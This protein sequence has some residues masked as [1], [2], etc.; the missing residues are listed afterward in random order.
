[1]ATAPQA[2]DATYPGRPGVIVFNMIKFSGNGGDYTGGLYAIRP[3]RE[4]PRQLTTNAWDYDPSFAPSGKRLVFRRTNSPRSGI[5]V[6][7]LRGGATKRVTSMGSDMDPAF[8]PQGM[9]VFSRFVEE[10]GYD[11]FLRTK[12]GRLRRLTSDVGRDLE[13][14]FT[15]DGERIVFFRDYRKAVLASL[16]SK[17]ISS[18]R[19]EGLYS[20]RIDGGGLRFLGDLGQAGSNFDISPSGRFLLFS[21]LG[22][23]T[24]DSV[25]SEARTRPIDGGKSRLVSKN[26]Q[27]STYSPGGRK[28]AYSNYKGLWVRATNGGAPTRIFEAEYRPFQMGGR[29]LVHPAWQPLP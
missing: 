2:A 7:D 11:L 15:P 28:I 4:N 16:S 8:G 21:V 27:F 12:E 23:V 25:E 18:E 13:A 9:V 14:T 3:G 6:L 19:R 29:L 5:Y 26:A 10:S 1:M 20:I 22:K 24:M 17:G